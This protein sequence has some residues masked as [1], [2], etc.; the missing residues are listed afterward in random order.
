MKEV[1]PDTRLIE[2]SVNR[3]IW[4][5]EHGVS[6]KSAGRLIA[7]PLVA[8][9]LASMLGGLDSEHDQELIAAVGKYLADR[10]G[11]D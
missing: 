2:T 7:N 11:Q 1:H 8:E 6:F 10:A 3:I 9:Q 5:T 4:L